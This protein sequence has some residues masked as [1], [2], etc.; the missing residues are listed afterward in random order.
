LCDMIIELVVMEIMNWMVPQI[1]SMTKIIGMA[2]RR[3][4][5]CITRGSSTVFLICRRV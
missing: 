2:R 1:L 4:S 3:L 5:T